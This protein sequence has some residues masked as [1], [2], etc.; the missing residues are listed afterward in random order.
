MTTKKEILIKKYIDYQNQIKT[1]VK[2]VAVIAVNIDA[3]K[4]VITDVIVE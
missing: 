3:F 1:N 4:A 2:P